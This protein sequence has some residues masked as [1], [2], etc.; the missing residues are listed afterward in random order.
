MEPEQVIPAYG[1]P[2]IECG[3]PAHHVEVYPQG[4]RYVHSDR[5]IRPC[6]RLAATSRTEHPQIPPHSNRP[7][8]TR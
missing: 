5:R 4:R 1:Q 2:C 8:R 3:Q 6:T 7:G